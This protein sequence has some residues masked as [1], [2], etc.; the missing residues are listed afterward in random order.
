MLQ[1]EYVTREKRVEKLCIN[2]ST[3]YGLVLWQCTEYLRSRLEG[4]KKWETTSN[5]RDQIELLKTFKSLSHKYDKDTEY[6]HVVYHTL[7]HRLMIFC[8]G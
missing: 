8:Q 1:V 7:L 6:H 4:Q 3:V 2:L 5:E